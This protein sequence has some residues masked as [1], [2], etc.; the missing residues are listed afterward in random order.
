MV[1]IVTATDVKVSKTKLPDLTARRS[2]YIRSDN[3]T[4]SYVRL[5][6]MKQRRGLTKQRFNYC[7]L[8]P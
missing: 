2:H 1:N 5:L 7:H 4:S 6:N 3:V 8:I